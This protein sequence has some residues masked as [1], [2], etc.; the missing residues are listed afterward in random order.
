[1]AYKLSL[2]DYFLMGYK[3]GVFKKKS[4][5]S[6]QKKTTWSV[7][8]INPTWS[9]QKKTTWSVQKISPTWSV[10]K[11]KPWKYYPYKYNWV[12]NEPSKMDGVGVIPL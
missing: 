9:V 4:T 7:Q 6:V 12:H 11:I 5:W 10:Q 3:L 2:M 8:K 1:M